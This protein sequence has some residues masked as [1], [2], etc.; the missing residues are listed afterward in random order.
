MERFD[1]LKNILTEYFPDIDDKKVNQLLTYYD[2]VIEKNKVMNLTAITE[3]KE[4]VFKHIVDSLQLFRIYQIKNTESLIDVGTGAGFPG[5]PLKILY[6][7]LKVTLFDSLQKRLTF[8]DE[9][10]SALGLTDIV[11]VHGRAEEFGRKPEFREQFDIVVSRA[12]A[13]LTSLCEISL[14]F[15]KVGG[16]FI[17]YKGGKGDEELK[18]AEYCIKQLACKIDKKVEFILSNDGMINDSTI[19]NSTINDKSDLS[20]NP[21]QNSKQDNEY[22]RILIKIKKTHPCSDK[23]PRAG[24]KPFKSPLY[25]VKR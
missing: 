4:F 23:Y 2:M 19:N 9:V 25:L 6:P 10:I 3:F 24:G 20:G 18:A 5:I 14:P 8:L 12:V 22:V 16:V 21:D 7:G 1:Y 13:E 15:C 11:T 17:A